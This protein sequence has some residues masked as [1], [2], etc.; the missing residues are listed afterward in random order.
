MKGR[1]G[2]P[3]MNVHPSLRQ[4]VP[5]DLSFKSSKIDCRATITNQVEPKALSVDPN[6]QLS[7]RGAAALGEKLGRGNGRTVVR[8]W[9]RS[10]WG[11]WVCVGCWLCAS[12][13]RC[14]G[15]RRLKITRRCGDTD[16]FPVRSLQNSTGRGLRRQRQSSSLGQW[17][18]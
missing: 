11:A 8:G 18:S 3:P 17:V 15:M 6:Q 2:P 16:F 1:R 10:G 14:A 13:L 7:A 4:A 9:G 5:M 12:P